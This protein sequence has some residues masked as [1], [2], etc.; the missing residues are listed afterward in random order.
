MRGVLVHGGIGTG[1]TLFAAWLGKFS[2]DA[3]TFAGMCTGAWMLR[4]IWLSFRKK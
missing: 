1:G 3:A 2:T 4:Q